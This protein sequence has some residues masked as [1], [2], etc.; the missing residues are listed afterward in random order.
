MKVIGKMINNTVKVFLQILMENLFYKI[1]TQ[2]N[3]LL[4]KIKLNLF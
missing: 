2:A 4:K 1:G 3:L